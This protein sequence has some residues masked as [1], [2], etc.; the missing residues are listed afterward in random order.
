MTICTH[1]YQADDRQYWRE[2]SMGIVQLSAEAREGGPVY[3][4]V[5]DRAV[6]RIL[7]S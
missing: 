5:P 3:H 4:L 6:T 2:A 1:G 7:Q